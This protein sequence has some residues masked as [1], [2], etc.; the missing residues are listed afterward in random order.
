MNN[1]VKNFHETNTLNDLFFDRVN[2]DALQQAIRYNVYKGTCQKYTIDKQDETQL[3]IVMRSIYL[4]YSN[5]LDFEIL[6]QIKTLNSK[7]L[8][9]CVKKII[10]ELKMHEKYLNDR[11]TISVFSNP[12]STSK[13]GLRNIG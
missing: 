1:I 9:Y 7:V 2:I 5:N 13:A 4:Q 8:E 3:L 11:D 6:E 10:Q 12:I